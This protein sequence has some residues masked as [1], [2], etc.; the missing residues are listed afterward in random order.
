MFMKKVA[1][2]VSL[3]C[4]FAVLKPVHP[5]AATFEYDIVCRLGTI[6][7]DFKAGQM[8]TSPAVFFPDN[9]ISLNLGD[10]LVVNLLFDHVVQV[11]DFGDPSEE[12][13]SFGLDWQDRS[14]PSWAGTWT[15]SI[16]ALGAKGDMWTGPFTANFQGSGAGIGWGGVR[17]PV[18]DSQGRF[19]GIRWTTTITSASEGDLPLSFTAFTGLTFH[20]ADAIKL[21][22]LKPQR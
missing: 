9:P 20:Y 11:F 15:S 6:T 19:T 10:T 16:E 7:G 2:V 5:Y 18:T 12:F 14:V 8:L 1:L 4:A 13:F 3:V 21:L 17:V 22:P